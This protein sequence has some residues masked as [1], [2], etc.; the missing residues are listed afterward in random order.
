MFVCLFV[1]WFVGFVLVSFGWLGFGLSASWLSLFASLSAGTSAGTS[2]SS[3]ATRRGAFSF[4]FFSDFQGG[5]AVV[6]LAGGPGLFLF[7]PFSSSMNSSFFSDILISTQTF[8]SFFSSSSSASWSSQRYLRQP[9][10]L[11]D[12]DQL[13]SFAA[14]RWLCRVPKTE[15]RVF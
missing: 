9:G 14:G 11:F 1:C 8:S 12:R 5:V 4:F 13:D 2:S 6:F 7:L 15:S 10:G 3:P